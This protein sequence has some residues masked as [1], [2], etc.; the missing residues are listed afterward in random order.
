MTT[1]R[2]LP[3]TL[4]SLVG[5]VLASALAMVGPGPAHAGPPT[6]STEVPCAGNH[7]GPPRAVPRLAHQ[8]DVVRTVKRLP[9]DDR[10]AVKRV[11]P[12]HFGVVALVSGDV[13]AARRDL[14]GV[15]HVVSWTD[16]YL[17]D[18]PPSM[19][20]GVVLVDLLRPVM[21]DVLRELRGVP[22]RV[23]P[24]YWTR[25][26]AVVLE[27]KAP[28]PEEVLAVAGVRPG[29]AEVRVVPR[30]YSQKDFDRAG[31]R[32]IDF[33]DDHD[34]DWSTLS[35]CA[36]GQGLELSIPGDP[37]DLTVTQEQLDES[38][39]M[40]VRVQGGVVVSF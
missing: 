32:L 6:A 10:Y 31:N 7:Y 2:L 37:D 4:A 20:M 11:R 5:G 35:G 22:G 9:A 14:D 21:N 33:L 23:G 25:G 18:F 24:A 12:T 26:G 1:R 40:P 17:S 8:R 38:A 13:D 29:G 34:V 28:V 3:R 36:S 27:W 16:H 39:G 19:R 15:R 30:A